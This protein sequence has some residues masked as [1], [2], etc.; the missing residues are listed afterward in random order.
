MTHLLP[1]T[2]EK[3]LTITGV[4]QHKLAAFGEAFL[5]L[6]RD[7]RD[8]NPADAARADGAMR[9]AAAPQ[10]APQRRTRAEGRQAADVSPKLSRETGDT[11]R[12]TEALL[13]E[14]HSIADIAGI[15]GL[16]VVTIHSHMEQLVANGKTFPPGRYMAPAR[17]AMFR[18][19]FKAADSW[20]L[21]PVVELSKA[22]RPP[23]NA[24]FEEA[25]LARILLNGS[26]PD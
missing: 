25:R 21:A 7:H 20:R 19:L 6:I 22:T 4:G 24:T 17:L 16:K 3:L 2:P 18:T 8:K 10:P 23:K 12:E 5:T 1:D 9:E 15:R 14:G 11:V 26:L 13:D